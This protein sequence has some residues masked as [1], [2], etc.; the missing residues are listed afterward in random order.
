MPSGW[1]YYQRYS[2]Y[3]NRREYTLI[4]SWTSPS[5]YLG[6]LGKACPLSVAVPV[7][8]GSSLGI[9][10]GISAFLPHTFLYPAYHSPNSSTPSQ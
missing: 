3:E 2:L 6:M 5:L 8:E 9:L 4:L 7:K 10:R 1:E